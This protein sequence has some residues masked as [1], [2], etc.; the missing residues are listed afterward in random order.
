M[1]MTPF[2]AREPYIAADAPSFRTSMNWIS[3][4]E[5]IFILP[6]V[7]TPSTINKGLLFPKVPA[8]LIRTAISSPGDPVT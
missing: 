7:G 3:F 8:P 5:N 1:R 2:D 6:E 4:T